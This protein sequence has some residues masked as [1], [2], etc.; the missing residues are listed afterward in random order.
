MAETTDVGQSALILFLPQFDQ[1]FGIRFTIRGV[2]SLN[3]GLLY[4]PF[5]PNPG[6]FQTVAMVPIRRLLWHT[7]QCRSVIN[8][9]TTSMCVLLSRN[10]AAAVTQPSRQHFS[11]DVKTIPCISN[12]PRNSKS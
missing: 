9:H 2:L 4:F 7:C 8:I 1:V 5:F 3:S 6:L 11:S 10:D 12:G